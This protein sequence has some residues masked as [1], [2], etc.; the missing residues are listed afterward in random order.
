MALRI[1]VHPGGDQEALVRRRVNLGRDPEDFSGVRHILFL[2]LDGDVA[3]FRFM[4]YSLNGACT[5]C[6][7]TLRSEIFQLPLP[8][9]V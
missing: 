5:L 6:L 7:F 8:L 2:S 4:C 9:E 3:H 1:G